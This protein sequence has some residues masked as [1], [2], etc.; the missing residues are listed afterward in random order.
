MNHRFYRFGSLFGLL[1][2]PFVCYLEVRNWEWIYRKNFKEYIPALGALIVCFCVAWVF[3]KKRR[4]EIK[5]LPSVG[6]AVVI[7]VFGVLAG[8]LLDFLFQ[9]EIS[10]RS[11][12]M[13][14]FW[15]TRK[16]A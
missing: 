11:G 12:F 14:E 8:C 10:L 9:A 5:L 15:K 16:K 4:R 13:N 6:A 1:L 2:V 3:D 7:Y